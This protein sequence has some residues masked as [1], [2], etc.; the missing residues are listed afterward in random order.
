M[1]FGYVI[2][3]V[4]DVGKALDF[5]EQAFGLKRQMV[6][7]D[8]YGDLA[9]GTTRLAFATESLRKSNGL[10]THDNRPDSLPAGIEIALVADNVQAAY[11]TAVAAGAVS[12][13]APEPKPWGQIVA[14]VR[15]LNGVL[16]ELCSHMDDTAAN[17]GNAAPVPDEPKKRA[18]PDHDGDVA[19]GSDSATAVDAEATPPVLEPAEA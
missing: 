19:R 3:Y 13:A 17:D 15:D 6:A 12:V 5:Y 14:Y 2:V 1:K 16:V 11:A 7:G 4:P 8:Q 10:T 9:T 18:R